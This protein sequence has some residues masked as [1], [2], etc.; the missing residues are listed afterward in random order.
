MKRLGM[1]TG[2]VYEGDIVSTVECTVPLTDEEAGD[3]QHIADIYALLHSSWCTNCT[4]C[5]LSRER[6]KKEETND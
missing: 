1:Y 3:E 2:R 4:Y 5:L 6:N